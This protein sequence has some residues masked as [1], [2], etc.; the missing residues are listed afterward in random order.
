MLPIQD[1][2]VCFSNGKWSAYCE[3]CESLCLFSNK[4]GALNMLNR[5]SCRYCR[6]DYRVKT[7]GVYKNY[8]DKWCSTCHL[9]GCE[10]AYTRYDHARQSTLANWRC[11]KCVA[12]EKGF[13][14]NATVGKE[15]RVYNRFRKS[16]NSRRIE[17]DITFEEFIS[18]YDGF[19]SLTGWGIDMSYSNDTAS[20]DRKDSSKGYTKDNIQWVHSMVNMSKNKYD[21][22][23]FINMCIAIADKFKVSL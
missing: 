20:L 6:K 23:K 1:S 21:Q 2:R 14:A 10:Q 11:K 3:G 7:D 19:C 13:S 15:Q 9:C 4:A 8:Q 16:A 22:N 12:K 18:S 5:G 17:W